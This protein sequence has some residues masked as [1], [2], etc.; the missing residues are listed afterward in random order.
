MP[1]EHDVDGKVYWFDQ[2][3]GEWIALNDGEFERFEDTLDIVR[4]FGVIRTEG[5]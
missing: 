5:V 4:G 3:N 2:W 1:I